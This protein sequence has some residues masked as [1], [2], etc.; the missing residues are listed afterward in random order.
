MIMRYILLLLMVLL[1]SC[2]STNRIRKKKVFVEDLVK[3]NQLYSV[4]DNSY[5]YFMLDSVGTPYLVK[6][7][8]FDA[9]RVIWTEK[10]NRKR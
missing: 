8:M 5:F 3:S 7:H 4:K 9:Q 6:T 1:T 10:L 2:G